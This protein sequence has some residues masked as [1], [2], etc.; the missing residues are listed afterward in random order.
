MNDLIRLLVVDDH[1]LFRKGLVGLL[2][3]RSDF[4]IVGEAASG[5]AAAQLCHQAQPDVILMDIH[6][7]GENGIETVRALKQNENVQI[8]MLTISDKDED[9]LAALDAG[10][11]G[12]LLKNAEPE[13][14]F[15]AIHHIAA[16]QG[17]LSPAITARVMQA[18]ARQHQEKANLISPREQE[19]LQLVAQGAK[20]AEIAAGLVISENTVKT[21]IQRVMR[22]LG[23][24]NRAAAVALAT[25]MGLLADEQD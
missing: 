12:Y 7:P 20:T 1:A 6:M 8:L 5:Q 21:H 17:V 18:A 2:S 3:E 11:D 14:L 25:Q 16:G 4:Q 22:K 10:A 24:A 9:L 23:A 19:I 13:E 15:R